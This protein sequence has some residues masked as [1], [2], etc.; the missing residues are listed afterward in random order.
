[1]SECGLRPFPPLAN[2]HTC[3]TP[4]TLRTN[5]AW[6]HRFVSTNYF[7]YVAVLQPF[8]GL[9]SLVKMSSEMRRS[10]TSLIRI[11]RMQHLLLARPRGNSRRYDSVMARAMQLAELSNRPRRIKVA[12][13]DDSGDDGRDLITWAGLAWV[14]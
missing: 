14:R 3:R 5:Y 10:T 11:A 4:D 9:N 6:S 8:T 12:P 1:M 2:T 13:F 7:V